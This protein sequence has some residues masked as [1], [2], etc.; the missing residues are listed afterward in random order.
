MKTIK[1][2][3]TPTQIS[4]LKYLCSDMGVKNLADFIIFAA[5]NNVKTNG[6]E[7]LSFVG[8]AKL[9]VCS[10]AVSSRSTN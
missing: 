6:F 3:A 2:K 5:E 7:D 4:I 1:K 9:I 10:L 8:A